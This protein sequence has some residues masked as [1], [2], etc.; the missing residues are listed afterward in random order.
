MT[1]KSF[2]VVLIYDMNGES[3]LYYNIEARELLSLL[4][5]FQET[6]EETNMIRLVSLPLSL[7]PL[8][9]TANQRGCNQSDQSRIG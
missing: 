5:C 9:F 1:T 3:Q 2:P 4:A 7:L 6:L 8:A